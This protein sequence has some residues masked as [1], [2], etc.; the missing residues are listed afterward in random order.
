V[1]PRTYFLL[2]GGSV[3]A[4][5]PLATT[6]L[7][8]EARRVGGQSR[9][10]EDTKMSDREKSPL[11]RLSANPPTAP[12]DPDLE[13]SASNP[14]PLSPTDP[15]H[16]VPDEDQE[17]TEDAGN[18]LGRLAGRPTGAKQDPGKTP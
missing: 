1:S 15:R 10:K 7:A 17:D 8:D 13:E 11:E 9:G 2:S 18:L 4:P 12:K 5:F 14:V 6:R 16:R 3:L